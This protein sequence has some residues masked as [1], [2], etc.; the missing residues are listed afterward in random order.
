M[1][2]DFH[3]AARWRDGAVRAGEGGAGV[4]GGG[5]RWRRRCGAVDA[6]GDAAARRRSLGAD[7]ERLEPRGAVHL[8]DGQWSFAEVLQQRDGAE[9]EGRDDD[10]DDDDSDNDND[11]DDYDYDGDNDGDNDDDND[12]WI[13]TMMM[14]IVI[15]TVTMTVTMTMTIELP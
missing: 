3:A 14:T 7:A 1:S 5:G 11:N 12:D 4:G 6:V 9:D 13:T 10:D 8:V 15:M 2:A